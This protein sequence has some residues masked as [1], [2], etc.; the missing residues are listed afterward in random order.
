MNIQK[1]EDVLSR[2]LCV[3]CGACSFIAGAAKVEMINAPKSGHR[4]LIKT[5]LSA[6]ENQACLA[7]CPG[8]ESAPPAF[9]NHDFNSKAMGPYIAVW[10]G[11]AV[12]PET[13]LKGSSGGALTAL[14]AYALEFE[15]MQGVLHIEQDPTRPLR[16]RTTYSKS[17]EE[18]LE[19]TGSRYAPASLLDQLEVVEKANGQSV[20]IGQP[21]EIVALRKIENVRPD[22]SEKVGIALSFFCA[23]SPSYEGTE[24]LIRKQ[25]ISPQDVTKLK[26]RGNGW[27]GLFSVWTRNSDDPVYQTT[28]AESWAFVQAFRAWAIHLWPDGSG[29]SAD[30]SCGDPWYKDV[31]KDAK[32]SSLIVARNKKGLEF[33]KAAAAAGYLEIS[34]V[35]PERMVEAQMNLVRKKGAIWGRLLAMRLFGMPTPDFSGYHLFEMWRGLSL[36]EKLQSVFGTL[37]RII[38]RK[39]YKAETIEFESTKCER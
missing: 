8:V 11:H 1:L 37:K 6:E 3:G 25:G 36:K 28:Y 22:L 29:E 10:E 5:N 23:G 24:S 27:P 38:K 14:A 2:R 17:K 20:I 39:L 32:G 12:D 9:S 33:V 16:N 34:E 4:P 30:I 21:S 26:Y 31:E 35:P 19:R 18:L 7:V 15:K 13:R